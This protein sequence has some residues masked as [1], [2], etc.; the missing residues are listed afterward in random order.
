MEKVTSDNGHFPW[1]VAEVV[2]YHSRRTN[3]HSDWSKCKWVANSL[4]LDCTFNNLSF[5]PVT[6]GETSNMTL[7]EL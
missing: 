4:D 7:T 1:F 6:S 5:H 3:L 2:V